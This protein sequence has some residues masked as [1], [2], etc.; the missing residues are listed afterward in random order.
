MT[1][2]SFTVSSPDGTAR[3]LELGFDTLVI[4]GWAGR[5]AAAIQHH[6]D[7]LAALG[8]APPSST[9]CFY[10][11]AAQQLSQADT[12]EVL[13]TDTS[14]EIECVLFGSP[15]GTLV[16]IGSDHTDR[17]TEAYS[18]AVSKQVCVKPVAREAWRYAEV[19]AHWDRLE[20]RARLVAADGSA[21]T[22]QQGSVD[23]LLPPATLWQRHGGIDIEALPAGSAMYSGTL[24]VLGEMAAMKSGDAFELELHD[25]VLGR[26]LR[27]LYAVQALPVVA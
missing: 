6:I 5:D 13:G 16:T 3:T 4:A 24:A 15:L 22:Y 2:L 26:S 25:P 10:R 27:H 23:G 19:A 11:V 14:G 18:V 20:L 21:R 17:K 9:P 7:E 8:V 12:V 1:Q